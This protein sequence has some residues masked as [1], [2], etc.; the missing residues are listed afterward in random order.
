M[1]HGLA[2][3]DAISAAAAAIGRHLRQGTESQ[4]RQPV[5][6]QGCR[7]QRLIVQPQ[8]LLEQHNRVSSLSVLR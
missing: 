1:L 2:V 6:T 8:V 4:Q 3:G 5:R 7:F